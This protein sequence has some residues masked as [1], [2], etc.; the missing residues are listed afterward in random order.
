M[1]RGDKPSLR[2]FYYAAKIGI[3]Q[4]NVYRMTIGEIT[5]M[6][7]WHIESQIKKSGGEKK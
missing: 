2:L 5:Q 4:D 6:W 1:W 7:Y 3:A